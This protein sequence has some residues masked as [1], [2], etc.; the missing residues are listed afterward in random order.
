MSPSVFINRIELLASLAVLM[1]FFY[2]PWQRLMVDTARQSLF[3]IRDAL[4]LMGTD[5]Q[6]DFNSTEYREL[7][8]HFNRLIRFAHV[9]NFRK[10]VAGMYFLPPPTSKQP[11]I[12]DILH[13]IPDQV[14]RHS[15]EAKW[16]RSMQILALTVLLR[17]STM[18]F[19]VAISFPFMIIAYIL[20][21]KQVTAV[22]HSIKRSIERDI[23]MQPALASS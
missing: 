9:L 10:L 23:N 21:P 12:A 4:F 13:R 19:L 16:R 8:E 6:L 2:G 14:V 22:D 5:G 17:S 11:T 1:W 3:E 15:I 7:R 18:M 20:D